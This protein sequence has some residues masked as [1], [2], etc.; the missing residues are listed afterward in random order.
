MLKML[1]VLL[2]PEQ[3]VP[4]SPCKELRCQGLGHPLLLQAP[5]SGQCSE[6]SST[7]D[8]DRVDQGPASACIQGQAPESLQVEEKQ[9]L[10]L[11]DT[12]RD[13]SCRLRALCQQKQQWGSG[14]R[15]G[16]EL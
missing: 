15:K 11:A 13:R 16:Q 8:G 12:S 2:Q 3:G 5:G 1:L 10:L 4:Q 6:Q 9:K 14:M 7:G